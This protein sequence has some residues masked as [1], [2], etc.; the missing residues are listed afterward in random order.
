MAEVTRKEGNETR[1]EIQRSRRH[2]LSPF[3]ELESFWED[4]FPA[5]WPMRWSN[6]MMRPFSAMTGKMPLVD[7]IDAEDKVIVRAELPGIEK[8][9]LDVSVSDHTV[10]IK[11]ETRHEEKEEK[12]DYYRSEIQRG[13]YARTVTLPAEVDGTKAKASLKDGMLELTLPKIEVS[14]RRHI[15]ID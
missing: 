12:G 5:G 3:D 7:V 8:K 9:D 13:A 4:T 11:A 14:K 15:K 1:Q 6:R 2:A 10:T